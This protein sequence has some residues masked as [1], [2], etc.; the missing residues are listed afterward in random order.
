MSAET[1]WLKVLTP[2]PVSTLT[3]LVNAAPEKTYI[4]AGG[5]VELDGKLRQVLEFVA[6]HNATTEESSAVHLR[7]ATKMMEEVQ[8]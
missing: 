5:C 1:I 4:R 7:D 3:E 2:V 8:E 6:I